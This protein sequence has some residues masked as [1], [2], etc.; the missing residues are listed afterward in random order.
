MYCW[1]VPGAFLFS[2]DALR[3]LIE[4]VVQVAFLSTAGQEQKGDRRNTEYS[5]NR[6]FHGQLLLFAII[7]KGYSITIEALVGE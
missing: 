1:F 7:P 4:G 3:G 6:G 5:D 2:G